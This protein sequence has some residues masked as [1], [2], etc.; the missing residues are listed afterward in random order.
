MKV[1][2]FRPAKTAMQS[3]VG[4]THAWLLEPEP[5][6]KI[7]DPLMGWSG[8]ADTS[9]QLR[10]SFDTKDEAVAWATGKGWQ[11]SVEE[12]KQRAV[13]PR[14]YSDNFAFNRVGRWTH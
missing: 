13:R 2:I 3:G 8:A 11:Y 9:S 12:P 4:N 10:L 7:A 14:A 5:S 1:R 6:R